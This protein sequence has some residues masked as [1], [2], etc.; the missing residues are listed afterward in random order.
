MLHFVQIYVILHI[1]G[2]DME[3]YT[4]QSPY[5]MVM[6]IIYAL[7]M[8]LFGVASFFLIRFIVGQVKAYRKSNEKFP[9]RLTV[10]LIAFCFIPIVGTV[11][12]GNMFIKSVSYDT[13]ME[14]GNAYYLEGDIEL[15]SCEE[16]YYRG[17]F[18]GYNVVIKFNEKTL[19][20]SNV[21]SSEVID[22]FKSDE[23][24]IVK[25][26]EIKNDGIYIWNIC[27]EQR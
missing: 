23:K 17:T 10:F 22:Y 15:V 7:A 1:S 21:F 24:L 19:S 27:T 2:D 16:E 6:N 26:G 3:I 20:P 14:K 11:L 13:K 18:M 25:Y 5:N 4:F 12:F 8:V 9:R